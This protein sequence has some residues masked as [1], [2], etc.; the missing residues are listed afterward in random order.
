MKKL[1]VLIIAALALAG[2]ESSP[3]KPEPEPT[4]TQT[5]SAQP[6]TQA[7][8]TSDPDIDNTD[9]ADLPPFTSGAYESDD[10]FALN[11]Q[12]FPVTVRVGVQDG[13]DRLVVEY[14]DAEGLPGYFTDGFTPELL[15]QGAGMPIDIDGE[16]LIQIMVSGIRYPTPDE[17]PDLEPD[18]PTGS[19]ITDVQVSYPFEG[20]HEINIGLDAEREYRIFYLE[21]PSRI[22]IDFKK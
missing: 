14:T 22:V 3:D 7:P 4:T 2:C 1:S 5:E 12:M 21:D 10:P 11:A 20:M 15:G 6:T 18:I 13:Y 16:A 17:N 9:D 8:E 19:V